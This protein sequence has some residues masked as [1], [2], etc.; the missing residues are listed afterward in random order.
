VFMNDEA[1]RK[2]E[3]KEYNQP[4]IG[5]VLPGLFY[6]SNIREYLTLMIDFKNLVLRLAITIY[7]EDILRKHTQQDSNFLKKISQKFLNFRL[8][9]SPINTTSVSQSKAFEFWKSRTVKISL[10]SNTASS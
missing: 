10:R 5:I 1:Q 2:G 4:P 7:P 3:G 8:R 6:S 9:G